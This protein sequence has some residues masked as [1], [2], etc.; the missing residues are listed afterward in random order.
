[1]DLVSPPDREQVDNQFEYMDWNYH[2]DLY[3]DPVCY[4]NDKGYEG[5]G[6]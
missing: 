5:R 1:M 2:R 6:F 4:N 3:N